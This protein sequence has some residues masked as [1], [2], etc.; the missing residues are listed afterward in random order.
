MRV[1]PINNVY[2]SQAYALKNRNEK[3]Q[4]VTKTMT[5]NVSFGDIVNYKECFE[6]ALTFPIRDKGDFRVVFK[7]LYLMLKQQAHFPTDKFKP[8]FEDTIFALGNP[9]SIYYGKDTE[10][11]LA[12]EVGTGSILAYA[13]PEKNF[14]TFLPPGNNYVLDSYDP[15]TC[16]YVSFARENNDFTFAKPNEYVEIWGSTGLIK[17][18]IDYWNNTVVRHIYYKLDGTEDGWK[19]FWYGTK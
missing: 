14:V 3:S 12:R 17:E 9:S 5:N 1:S 7:E 2:S 18:E 4:T 13:N 8:V 11:A 10:I 19:T 16:D 15:V 6:R